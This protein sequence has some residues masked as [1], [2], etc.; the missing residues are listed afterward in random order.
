MIMM[1]I[2][3][4]TQAG[5]VEQLRFLEDILSTVAGLVFLPIGGRPFDSLFNPD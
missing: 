2:L 3:Q 4:I 5:P 1:T